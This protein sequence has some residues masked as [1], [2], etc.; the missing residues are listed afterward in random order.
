[1]NSRERLKEII[2]IV[3]KYELTKS[4]N[5]EKVRMIIEDLGPTFIKLGQIASSREDLIPKE[6]CKELSKLKSSVKEVDF[7]NTKKILEKEY[8]KDINQIFKKINEKP[9]GSASIA[10]VYEGYLLDGSKVAIKVK[11]ENIDELMK[12]D[13]N[14]LKKAI[15]ILHLN[16]LI[17]NIIDLE[18]VIDEMYEISKEEMNF[19]IERNHM[20]EFFEYNKDI[21]YL[22]NI[23]TYDKLS[24]ENVLVMEYVDGYNINEQQKLIEEG[25]DLKEI[26]LKLSDN[27]IKQAIDDGFYHADPHSDNIKIKDGKIVYLD[28][29]MMGR[30][31][32][33]NRGLLEKCIQAIIKNDISEI[34]HILVSFDTKKSPVD[35]MKLKSDIKLVLDKN[36]QTEIKSI[37]IKTFASDM[38]S[39]LQENSITLPKEITMLVRGIVVLEG[40]LEEVD[41][42]I[43]LIEVLKTRLNYTDIISKENIKK[44]LKETV[45][46]ANDLVNIPNE[47][48]TTLKGVNTGELRF[49]IELTD[50]KHQIDRIERIVH[51]II[52]TILDVAFILGTSLIVI[53]ENNT[54]PFIFYLYLMGA[55]LCSIW[56]IY[57]LL[58]SKINKY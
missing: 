13:T 10:Q 22:K 43:N 2:E 1:M 46:N 16:K 21:V 49:N 34:A 41:N 39:L 35:Y 9:I 50:S 54:Y 19:N 29:G 12:L 36:K 27:Y 28:Y 3:K 56:L 25:Y 31:S 51:L 37:N 11:R 14:L 44:V 33:Y 48:L 4:I 45:T 38:L 30:L 8:N 17:G 15:S 7:S 20:Q 26:A 24:T 53:N 32:K 18:S 55:I 40:T 58:M 42:N 47:L 23:K 57:K 6:Y 5:P 52:V